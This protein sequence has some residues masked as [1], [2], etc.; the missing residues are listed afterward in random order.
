MT[1]LYPHFYFLII[2]ILFLISFSF[3]FSLSILKFVIIKNSSL[4]PAMNSIEV[5]THRQQQPGYRDRVMDIEDNRLGVR[6][7]VRGAEYMIALISIFIIIFS[8]FFNFHHNQS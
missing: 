5:D 7:Q 3:I 6:L 8:D 1:G 2:L 4:Y